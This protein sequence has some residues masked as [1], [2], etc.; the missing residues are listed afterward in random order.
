LDTWEEPLNAKPF[1]SSVEQ[2][3]ASFETLIVVH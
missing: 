1:L 2:K 3:K